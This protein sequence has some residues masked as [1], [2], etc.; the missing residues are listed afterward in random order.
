M[1][2]ADFM[3]QKHKEHKKR[4][5]YKEHWAIITMIIY[6]LIRVFLKPIIGPMFARSNRAVSAIFIQKSGQFFGRLYSTWLLYVLI[7]FH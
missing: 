2:S 4:N 6:L 5:K 3:L 7:I 1:S